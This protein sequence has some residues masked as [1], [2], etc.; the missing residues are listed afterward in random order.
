MVGASSS[1]LQATA[2]AVQHTVPDPC[3]EP[4]RCVSLPA[5]LQLLAELGPGGWFGGGQAIYG[6]GP[7]QAALQVVAVGPDCVVLHAHLSGLSKHGGPGLL[8]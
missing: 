4:R 1:H 3:R 6:A 2:D 8:K 7:L 5:P